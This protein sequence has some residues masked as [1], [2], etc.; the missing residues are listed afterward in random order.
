MPAALCDP[1]EQ[2]AAWRLAL[3]HFHGREINLREHFATVT[4]WLLIG[5]FASDAT[6]SAHHTVFPPEQSLDL[7][8]ECDGMNGKVRWQEHHQSGPNASVDFKKVFQ[9]TEH[10]CAYALCF[11]TS[12]EQEAQLRFASND[13]GKVWLGGK[14]VHDY[15]HEGSTFLDRDIVPVRLPKGAT[16]LLLKVTNN[17]GNWGFVLRFTDKQGRPLRNL[18]FG[19]SPG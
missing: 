11:V 13:A 3:D 10:V 19:L 7:R 5:P 16:P 2:E 8:A 4:D 18:K 17:L 6:L 12:I 14:L 15:P 1:H 9:P